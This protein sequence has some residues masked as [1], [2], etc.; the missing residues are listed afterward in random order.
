MKEIK[1]KLASTNL[2]LEDDDKIKDK[3][4]KLPESCGESAR[5]LMRERKLFTEKHPVFPD[6][7][8]DF[9]IEKLTHFEENW[10]VKKIIYSNDEERINQF[11]EHFMHY[12]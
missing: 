2:Y 11:I 12:R 1:Q 6:R 4:E 10:D 5:H 3:F 7:V 8:I 9:I